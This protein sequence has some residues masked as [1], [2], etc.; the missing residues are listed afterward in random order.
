V[1]LGV[2]KATEESRVYYNKQMDSL[3]CLVGLIE[4]AKRKD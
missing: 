3:D 2:K 4:F 1:L